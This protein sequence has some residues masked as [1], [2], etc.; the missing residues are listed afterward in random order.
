MPQAPPEGSP[1]LM[2]YRFYTDLPAALEWLGKAFGF[3]TRLSMPGVNQSLYV[4]VN[5]VDG[6]FERARAG[7]AKILSE[8]QDVFW[9][10]RMYYAQGCGGHHWNFAQNHNDIAPEDIK[11]PV[12]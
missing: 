2:P 11:P 5:D 7:G 9:G 8:P 1:R 4:Y 10:D 6:H 12:T 3:Q